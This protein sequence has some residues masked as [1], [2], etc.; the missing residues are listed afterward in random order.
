MG[1]LFSVLLAAT[2]Q[3]LTY[4]QLLD[5]YTGTWSG[6]YEVRSESGHLVKQL[7]AELQYWWDGDVQRSFTVFHD[8]DQII[9]SESKFFVSKG[10]LFAEVQTGDAE[11]ER[12]IGKVNNMAI[13]WL[14]TNVLAAREKQ[15]VEYI[16]KE[17]GSRVLFVKGFHSVPANN[18]EPARVNINGE[19]K[20]VETK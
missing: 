7:S 1:A 20:F 4:R 6:D 10:T 15:T 12:F 9:Y 17:K 8:G 19:F 13:T 14:P 16:R 5:E 3:G 11:I 2:S 18:G